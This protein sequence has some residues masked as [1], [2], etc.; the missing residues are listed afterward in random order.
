MSRRSLILAACWT[1]AFV[2]ALSLDSTAA[3]FVHTS[4]LGR[5]VEGKPWAQVIKEP[6]EIGFTV[7]VVAGLLLLRRINWKQAVFVLAV[8]VASGG[9]I[10]PKW[11]LGRVRPYKLPGTPQPRPFELQP[12]WNGA[13]GFFHQKDLTFPSGHECTAVAL[14]AA[15]WI[16]WPRGR[17]FF[18]FLAVCVGI[19]RVS[20]N[21][22]YCSD[23][24]AAAGYGILDAKLLHMLLK[25]WMQPEQPRGF[26]V[27]PNASSP[28]SGNVSP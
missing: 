2:A 21:A 15:M 10:F 6:G 11:L 17:W 28:E 5:F 26:E 23:V 12:F 20:E 9:N 14:A 3:R 25:N 7:A 8:G 16:V 19:E 18:V 4:G 27:L 13:Y 22:H 24:I 1:I